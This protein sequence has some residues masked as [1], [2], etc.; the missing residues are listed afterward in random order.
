MH[1]DIKA[2]NVLTKGSLCCLADFGLS[3]ICTNDKMT[4]ETGSYRWMA[5]ELIRHEN[6]DKSCD[7]YSLAMLIYEMITLSVPFGNFSPVEAALGITI[8]GKR[9]VLPPVP[10]ELHHLIRDCWQQ[11]S[12]LRPNMKDV[13]P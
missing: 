2:E 6:Y 12:S 5:P 3:R 10:T 7:T 13:L 11:A 1:R 8:H 9:P 4:I